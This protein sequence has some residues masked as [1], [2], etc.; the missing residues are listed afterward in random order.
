MPIENLLSGHSRFKKQFA[1]AQESYVRLAEEAQSP[2]VLWIGCA[3]SRVIPEQITQSRPGDLFVMRNVAN[4]VPPAGVGPAVGTVIEYAVLHLQVDHIVVCGHTECQG[5]KALENPVD[6]IKE[7]HIARWIELVRPAFIQVKTS[8][9][10]QETQ[11]LETI[12]ANVL[13]QQ[14]NLLTYRCVNEAISA[15]S[16]TT[17]AWLYDLH[18][19]NLSAYN[20]QTQKW[21]LLVS[22]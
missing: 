18:T 13:L 20:D 16:L 3:D 4:V 22:D 14:K 7:P 10:P 1:E 5:I 21:G 15:G 11:Y 19:G 12:K 8:G 17:H 9:T 6:V 2:A